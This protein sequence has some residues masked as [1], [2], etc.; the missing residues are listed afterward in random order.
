MHRLTDVYKEEISLT[1]ACVCLS[2]CLSLRLLVDSVSSFGRIDER[3]EFEQRTKVRRRR[4]LSDVSR[5]RGREAGETTS[6]CCLSVFSLLLAAQRNDTTR[7]S[8]ARDTR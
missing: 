3:A 7:S 5:L 1:A 6:L 2:L 4:E 8:A